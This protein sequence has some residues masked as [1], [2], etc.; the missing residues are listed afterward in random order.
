MM[1]TLTS[2]LV[3]VLLVVSHEGSIVH[4]SE[5]FQV[6]NSIRRDHVKGELESH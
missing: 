6:P 3:A 5:R 2:S 1:L 4:S